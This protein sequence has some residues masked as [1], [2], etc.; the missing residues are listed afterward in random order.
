MSLNEY[1]TKKLEVEQLRVTAARGEMEL[2]IM[3][4]QQD[5]DKLKEQIQNTDERL[6]QIKSELK[7]LK[8]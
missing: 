7:K 6:E 5:I 4:R 8:N 3:E 1:Q 2:K